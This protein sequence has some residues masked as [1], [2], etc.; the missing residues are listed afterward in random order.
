V[1][2][3]ALVSLVVALPLIPLASLGSTPVPDINQAAQDS[4][5]WPAYVRQ[6]AG[7]YRTLTPDER[8]HAIVFASNY[9]EAGA[10]D[11]YG[12]A[13]GLPAVYSGQNQLYFQARPPDSATIAV[14]VGGQLDDLRASFASCA[15]LARL[16][17]GVDVDNEEQG[18]PVAVCRNPVGGWAAVWPHTKHAD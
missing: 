11:R 8:A 16:D 7:A 13:Y 17:N 14:V 10:V 15:V 5:G 4:V 3:N 2:V 9:G 18:E 1:L 6:V 12:G